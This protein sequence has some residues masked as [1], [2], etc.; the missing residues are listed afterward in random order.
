M[1]LEENMGELKPRPGLLPPR[2]I[3]EIS[4]VLAHG[5]EKYQ[6]W[7]W[8]EN[9]AWYSDNLDALGRHVLEWLMG[10]RED[11]GSGCH[12]LAHAASRILFLL[13]KD[14]EERSECDET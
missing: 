10:R 6:P 14:L 5:A 4:R 8:R 12:P 1:G 7:G 11:E 3:S 9:E 13:E 2:A